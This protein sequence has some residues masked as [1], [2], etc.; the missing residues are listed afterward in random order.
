MTPRKITGL[1]LILFLAL[2]LPL[3]T[4][5]APKD[6]IQ[7]VPVK[8]GAQ[9]HRMVHMDLSKPLREI[10]PTPRQAG[11]KRVVPNRPIPIDVDRT[12]P[13]QDVGVDSVIQ[14][15]PGTAQAPSV[16]SNFLG[17]GN[18]FSGPQGTWSVNVAPPDTVG[19]VGP[20]YIVQAVNSGFAIFNKTGT[21]LYGPVNTNTIF[22]GFGGGCQTNNDGDATV[23][24]D[25][26]S[27]RWIVAQFSVSTT[28]Y[29]ECV[30]VSQTSDPRGSWYRFSYSFGSTNFNDYPKFGVWPD[31]YYI[32]YNIFGSTSFGEVCAHDR[33]KMLNGQANTM[34]CFTTG[35]NVQGLLPSDM[36][37]SIQP[38]A[39]SPNYVVRFGS[40]NLQ[41]WKF[42]VDWTTPA[43]STFTG[44]TNIS[45]ASFT[46][47]CSTSTRGA[48]VPQ[49]NGGTSYYLEA[50]ADRLMNRFAYRNFGDH[51]SLTVAHSIG[52][53]TAANVRWYEL[54]SPNATP[55]VYQS[56]SYGPDTS[57]RWVA[58]TA[59]D[60]QG[61]MAMGYS[62]S[63][64]S[65]SP[66]I[67]YTTRN[68]GDAPGTMGTE[69]DILT[70]ITH[71]SQIGTYGSPAKPLQRW[72]DYSSMVVDPS[73]DCTFWYTTEYIPTQ[74]IFNWATRIASFK[75]PT[76]SGAADTTP[77][78]TSL[79]APSSGATLTAT[80][81]VSANASDNVGVT[82]VEFYAGA[83]LIGNDSSSPYSISWDT[84]TVA[85]GSYN[86]TSKAYDAAG[87]SASS[88]VVSVT[89]SN[90]AGPPALTATY[91]STYKAPACGSGGKSCDSGASL[92]NGRA[93]ISGGAESSQPNTIN[94]SCA[95]GT[96]GTYHSDESVDR[97]SVATVSGQAL[98]GGQS[99]TVSVTVWCY[100]TMDSLD[101]YYT[102]SIPGTGA[103]TWTLIGTQACTVSGQSV[104]MTGTYTL[105]ATGTAHAVRANY[106]YQGSA[107]ACST[108][109]YDDHDDLV[110][111]VGQS[112]DTTAPTTSIT[113]PAAGATVANTI[114]VSANASDNVGVTNVEFYAGATLIGS[115]NSSPYSISWNTTTVA[116]GSYNLTSKAYD[117]AGNTGTSAVVSVTVS[118]DTTP[119]TTSITAP[120][121]G[122]TI[123][124]N[125]TVSANASDNVGVTRVDFYA[126]ATLIGTDST[127]PY[128][129]T[130]ITTATPNGAYSLTTKAYDAANNSGTS[131]AVSVTVS[132][133]GGASDLMAAYSSTYKAPA[134]P[135]GGKSC[136]TGASII[137]GRGTV[138]P[139]PNYSNTINASCADGNS[140]TYHLDESIDAMKIATNDGTALASGK[141]VTV[142]VTVYCYGSSDS[143][144]LYRT[145][146][147]PGTG[148]PSWT[149]IGTQKCTAAGVKS[150]TATYT[151]PTGANQ[152][153]RGNF[154]YGSTASSCRT[155]SYND[156]DDLVFG[157]N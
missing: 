61:N 85:N 74:G 122:A 135:S 104:V 106:R 37:G 103:P 31:G 124:G 105:P 108:G 25:Q 107:S 33:S 132:N 71:A 29:L 133:G 80:A 151:L 88:T 39:G 114:T 128:S 110:F 111:G 32:T 136:D 62:V 40:N 10:I 120:A 36:D 91:N 59:M 24:Y 48:C 81:T 92:L 144:D 127:S 102:S 34:Q 150:F 75:I 89:V 70:S 112:A 64:G 137:N 42:H 100:G 119:P 79:T 5:A 47:S 30:A 86:L 72:G 3:S 90:V 154:R 26:M 84:T 41:L 9:E 93:N 76:C 126:G 155:G 51:E 130:W 156:H 129:I 123:S 46:A 58:S 49:A 139:E 153:V 68:A 145:A 134:C 15:A 56:G 43:N 95:D 157:V 16:N 146:S 19:D 60:Q 52:G 22:S 65:I 117:A 138:G 1:F 147:I 20:N 11:V 44:P 54:R 118:N 8:R 28:P 57:W 73:D 35:S 13:V 142:T 94:T 12:N 50:L 143:L 77:P 7:N 14:M 55:T 21:V 152:A 63:S 66:T 125:A 96:S 53:Q 99:A 67:R 69:A 27:D 148:S 141:A 23:N 83:T 115:D 78:T 4:F 113:A 98:A 101:L 140:G 149:L 2:A 131:S 45:V 17:V 87:N 97:I 6:D 38:P 121:N 18:G 109:A 116:N 82:N